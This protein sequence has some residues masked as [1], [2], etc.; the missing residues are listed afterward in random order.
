MAYSRK[1]VAQM[2]LENVPPDQD[3]ILSFAFTL[4][5][6]LDFRRNKRNGAIWFL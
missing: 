6:L 5:Y 1:M 4:V 3:F 2:V